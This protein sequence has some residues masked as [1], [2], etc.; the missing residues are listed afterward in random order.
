[1]P[2]CGH[3]SGRPLSLDSGIAGFRIEILGIA[4]DCIGFRRFGILFRLSHDWSLLV[5]CFHC[6]K[7]A[8]QTAPIPRLS[9]PSMPT[10]AEFLGTFEAYRESQGPA[11]MVRPGNG[12]R[13]RR[14]TYPPRD[15]RPTYPPRRRPVT[16][17][18]RQT[19]SPDT[20]HASH[21]RGFYQ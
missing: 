20:E 3:S 16:P 8:L 6:I 5:V 4:Q 11:N 15:R 12:D 2:D 17:G 18:F 10:L 14:P 13:D 9:G 21:V 19:S 7:K 1:M